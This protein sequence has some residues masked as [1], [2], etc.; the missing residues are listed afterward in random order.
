[1]LI[2]HESSTTLYLEHAI[3]NLTTLFPNV[4]IILHGKN[5]LMYPKNSSRPEKNAAFFD[6][7]DKYLQVNR[8]WAGVSESF[9]GL[10]NLRSSYIQ[11]HDALDIGRRLQSSGRSGD[12]LE[13]EKHDGHVF[14]FENY[15]VYMLLAGR[16]RELGILDDIRRYDLDHNTD[17]YHILFIFLSFDRQFTKTAALLH[18][19]RNNVIYH[20]GRITDIFSLD[21]DDPEQR[22]RLLLL[23]RLNDLLVSGCLE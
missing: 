9:L 18:M 8:A 7:L 14:R 17:Y 12:M 3:Q 1:M 10:D 6:M 11:A 16:Q 19:H 15:H 22:L 2:T 23:Y 5:I 13:P 21:L 4:R 20:I